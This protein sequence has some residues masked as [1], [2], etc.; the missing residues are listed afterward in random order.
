MLRPY[1]TSSRF[2][3]QSYHIAANSPPHFSQYHSVATFI[4]PHSLHLSVFSTGAFS[5]IGASGVPS[6]TSSG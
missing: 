1:I 6:S 3:S 4:V 5:S 2:D